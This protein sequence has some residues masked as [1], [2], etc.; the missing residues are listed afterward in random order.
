MDSAAAHGRNQY[1]IALRPNVG[2]LI[3]VCAALNVPNGKG[4]GC[5]A[6]P[7]IPVSCTASEVSVG[8]STLY[9]PPQILHG[10]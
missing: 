10:H 1:T 2:Y 7:Q 3:F 8:M 6:G 9:V 4:E 5:I